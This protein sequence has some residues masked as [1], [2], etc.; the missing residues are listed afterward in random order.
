MLDKIIHLDIT[1]STNDY[2]LALI[3]SEKIK[4]DIAIFADIQTAGRG[5]LNNRSWISIAGNLHCSYILNVADLGVAN[6]ALA[7]LNSATLAAVYKLLVSVAAKQTDRIIIKQPNDI[8]VDHLKIAGVLIETNWPYAVIGI[9]INLINSPL[10]TSANIKT[11]FGK[12]LLPID[13]I[14]PLYNHIKTAISAI[15]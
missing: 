10:Q 11:A 9:G 13:V 7:L 1:K 8:L 12:I 3:A 15:I 6:S 4:S 2:A 5:R 14:N